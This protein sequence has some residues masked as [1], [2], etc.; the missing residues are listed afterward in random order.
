MLNSARKYSCLQS[1][2]LV[3]LVSSLFL[4]G[5]HEVVAASSQIDYPLAS[6]IYIISPTNTTYTSRLLTLNASV[7]GLVASNIKI[8]MTYSL[9]GMPNNT[10]PTVI[11]SREH[12]FVV[13]RTGTADLPMLSYGSHNL[14]VYAKHEITDASI[15]GVYYSKY[16]QYKNCTVYFTVNTTSELDIPEFP[17]SAPLLTILLPA[18]ITA[19]IYRSSIRKHNRGKR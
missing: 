18:T 17:S 8:S 15:E 11:H 14:T 6:G 16:V 3:S 2:I 1:L 12:S 13:T 19:L 10:L 5:V 9:D 7:T 4:F